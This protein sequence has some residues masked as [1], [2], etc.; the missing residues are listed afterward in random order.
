VNMA[1]RIDAR[2]PTK[3]L[4]PYSGERSVKEITE[5]LRQRLIERMV[6]AGEERPQIDDWPCYL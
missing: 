1:G 2:G 4:L 3:R 5:H 6:E